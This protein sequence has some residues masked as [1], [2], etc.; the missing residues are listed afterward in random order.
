[1]QTLKDLKN[2]LDPS[3]MTPGLCLYSWDFSLN[4]CDNLFNDKF[5]YDFRCKVVVSGATHVTEL[6]LDPVGYT[7]PLIINHHHH[8]NNNLPFL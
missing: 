2:N 7:S 1:M 6:V 4:Q 8:H 5:T 3:S